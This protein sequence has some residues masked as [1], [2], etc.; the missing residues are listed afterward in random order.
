ML[1]SA[2][3]H[4]L[5]AGTVALGLAFAASQARAFDAVVTTCHDGDTC[6]VTASDGH[7]LHIRL[8]AIDAPEL[9][10]PS[11]TEA[12]A[13]ISELVVG[14]QVDIRPTGGYSHNRMIADMNVDGTDV[15]AFMVSRGYAWVCT[16][17]P[18]RCHFTPG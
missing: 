1:L 3:D 13:L 5:L 7:R 17:S 2:I 16:T 18:H 8:H 9:D 6:T 10:Q 14:H 15:A 12:Q 4:A 11:G